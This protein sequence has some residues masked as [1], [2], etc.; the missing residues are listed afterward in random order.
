MLRRIL[1]SALLAIACCSRRS[2]C[3]G[4][5]PRLSRCRLPITAISRMSPQSIRPGGGDQVEE[6]AS[7]AS[8]WCEPSRPPAWYWL[9]EDLGDGAGLRNEPL[10]TGVRVPLW[11]IRRF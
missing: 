5:I 9:I 6:Q 11:V 7:T 8:V 2:S 1:A 3:P 10:D 4:S